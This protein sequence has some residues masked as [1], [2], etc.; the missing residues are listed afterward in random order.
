MLL[1]IVKEFA[2]LLCGV[3]AAGM[4]HVADE[5]CGISNLKLRRDGL[6]I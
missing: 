3:R 2:C 6:L 4:V 5:D 1:G